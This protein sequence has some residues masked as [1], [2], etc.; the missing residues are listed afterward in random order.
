MHPKRDESAAWR[1]YR[2]EFSHKNAYQGES[3]A[4]SA[5][6]FIIDYGWYD[7]K[8]TII[9]YTLEIEFPEQEDSCPIGEGYYRLDP[10]TRRIAVVGVFR[11]GRS[12]AG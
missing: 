12:G 4:S 8:K 10:L 11:D 1:I 7:D 9:K 5:S 3:D 6:L 2:Y